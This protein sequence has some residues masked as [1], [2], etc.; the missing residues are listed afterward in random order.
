MGSALL[1][2]VGAIFSSCREVAE[3]DLTRFNEV[4][5]AVV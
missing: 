4:S 3:Y 2:L 5:S 1:L